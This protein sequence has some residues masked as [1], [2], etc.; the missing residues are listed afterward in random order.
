MLK[1]TMIILMASLPIM[2]F[3]DEGSQI[4]SCE[5]P[6]IPGEPIESCQVP[7]GYFYPAEYAVYGCSNYHLTFSA[8]LLLW[9]YNRDGFNDL[10]QLQTTTGI[11][12]ATKI[13]THTVGYQPSFRLTAALTLPCYDNWTLQAN[14]IWYH[15]KKTK[16]FHTTGNQLIQPRSQNFPT[17]VNATAMKSEFKVGLDILDL[18]VGREFYLSQ[19]IIILPFF[20]LRA[21]WSTQHENLTFFVPDRPFSTNFTRAGYWGVGPF[22]GADI[23][24]LVWCGSYLLARAGV[25]IPYSPD[26]KYKVVKN[27]PTSIPPVVNTEKIGPHPSH[28]P[29]MYP[30][31]EA[32]IGLGWGTY[33]C[34]CAYHIDIK[35]TYEVYTCS[36]LEYGN[37]AGNPVRENTIQG[38]SIGG[39]F[40]F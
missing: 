22:A 7:A 4:G 40:D 12:T 3:A 20:G 33:L 9:A 37:S 38:F 26:R 8:D 31:T 32:G 19:R 34:G 5:C 24:G 1:N 13:L 21:W 23:R 16:H 27:F 39:Q 25:S 29:Y 28:Y 15:H 36:F 11:T 6:L 2:G 10:G 18:T 35:A 30:M 17:I 14:Y